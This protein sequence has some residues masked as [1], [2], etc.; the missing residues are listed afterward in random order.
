MNE[1][2]DAIHSIDLFSP[3]DDAAVR[4]LAADVRTARFAPGEMVIRAGDP[5]DTMFLVRDGQLSVRLGSNGS[6]TARLGP[7][8]FFGE[9]SLLTGSPRQATVIALESCEL[10][11]IDHDAFHRLLSQHPEV[12]QKVSEQ[13]MERRRENLAV[14]EQLP[15]ATEQVTAQERD[16]LVDRI[17]SFFGLGRPSDQ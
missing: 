3:L 1:R 10:I 8:T 11:V 4:S 14:M 2:V 17:K 12:A 5:G 15:A 9:M 16:D 6:E 13:V 7:G